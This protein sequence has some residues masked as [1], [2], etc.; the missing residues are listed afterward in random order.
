MLKRSTWVFFLLFVALAGLAIYLQKREA[1]PAPIDTESLPTIPVTEFL[2]PA[3]EGVVTSIFIESRDGKSLGLE[4]ENNAWVATRPFRA[5][6]IQSSVEEAAS[7]VTALTVLDHL[8]LSNS[9][10]GLD[11]PAY[12]ITIGF[13]SGTF[14]IAMIGDE[15]PIGNGYY[16]RKEGGPVLVVSKYGLLALISMLDAPPYVSSPTPTIIPTPTETP[17]PLNTPTAA[18]STEALTAT[19]TP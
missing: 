13:S 1:A 2:F 6:A 3:E 9:D 11:A 18:P 17:T 14:E 16:A 7:Q 4:R 5:E 10:V 12:T 15:T 19:K 8:E